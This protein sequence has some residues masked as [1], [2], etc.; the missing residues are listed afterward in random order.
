MPSWTLCVRSMGKA[1]VLVRR[2]RASGRAFPRRAWERDPKAFLDF[3][4]GDED[5]LKSGN[6]LHRIAPQLRMHGVS[7]N[8]VRTNKARLITL[9]TAGVPISPPTHVTSSPIESS[10]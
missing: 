10:S 5:S 8:L 3:E 4:I 2:R 6:E 9:T 1:S 7:V